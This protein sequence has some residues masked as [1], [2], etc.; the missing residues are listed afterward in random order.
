M[1]V[2]HSMLWSQQPNG[3]VTQIEHI[4]YAVCCDHSSLMESHWNWAQLHAVCCD[5]NSLMESCSNWAHLHAACCDHNSLMQSHSNWAHFLRGMLW[6]QQPNGK[7]VKLRVPV[8]YIVFFLS[9]CQLYKA[10]ASDRKGKY[11]T[12]ICNQL[13]EDCMT[14]FQT[15]AFYYLLQRSRE[16]EVIH[17]PVLYNQWFL[18]SP[19]KPKTCMTENMTVRVIS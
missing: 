13:N 3:K 19:K 18:P 4:F 14:H 12:W 15:K 8:S 1:R 17:S 9:C 11:S 7:S 5:H 16:T 10:F 2:T 6:S